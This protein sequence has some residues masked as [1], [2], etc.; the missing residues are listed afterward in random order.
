M[1][2]HRRLLLSPLLL[3]P[4]CIPH[5]SSTAAAPC[6]QTDSFSWASCGFAS[7]ARSGHEIEVRIRAPLPYWS[8]NETVRL[9]MGVRF[10]AT[11]VLAGFVSW[12]STF[13]FDCYYRQ[14]SSPG[15]KH[16]RD[17]DPPFPGGSQDNVFWFLQVQACISQDAIEYSLVPKPSERGLG[18]RLKMLVFKYIYLLI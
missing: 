7:C 13:A 11:L 1:E 2:F 4:L 18:T 15:G 10:A 16:P 6:L 14:P 8:R 9:K 17:Q 3:Q 5:A 12:L